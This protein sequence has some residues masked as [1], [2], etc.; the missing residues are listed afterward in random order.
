VAVPHGRCGL[1]AWFAVDTTFMD[2]AADIRLPES[3]PLTLPPALLVSLYELE[4][5]DAAAATYC[6]T[7]L[8]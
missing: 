1:V 5:R 4:D 7:R 8:G 2:A 3:Y 6:R